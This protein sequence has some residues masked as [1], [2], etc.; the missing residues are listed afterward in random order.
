MAI[1]LSIL[2]PVS[3]L[4]I[5]VL[6]FITFK[7]VKHFKAKKNNL[8]NSMDIL[9]KSATID[10]S[11]DSEVTDMPGGA[12]NKE[13]G[14]SNTSSTGSNRGGGGY[15]TSSNS[16]GGIG[17]GVGGSGVSYNSNPAFSIP[18]T[19]PIPDH[20]RRAVS[21]I[22]RN[23]ADIKPSI[24]VHDI[25]LLA[26]RLKLINHD[27]VLKDSFAVLHLDI[28]NIEKLNSG[29]KIIK[30]LLDNSG[31]NKDPKTGKDIVENLEQYKD[32]FE[33]RILDYLES[34]MEIQR[35]PDYNCRIKVP[36][37]NYEMPDPSKLSLRYSEI[38]FF[39][40]SREA[41]IFYREKFD[42]HYK[43]IDDLTKNH[44]DLAEAI[45]KELNNRNTNKNFDDEIRNLNINIGETY[46]IVKSTIILIKEVEQYYIAVSNYLNSN[47]NNKD[48]RASKIYQE[49]QEGAK[50]ARETLR[51][52]SEHFE[53]A[54]KIV[55][56]LLINTETKSKTNSLFGTISE[57]FSNPSD[58]LQKRLGLLGDSFLES[59]SKVIQKGLDLLEKK[60]KILQMK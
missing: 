41:T 58:Y 51:N 4:A 52:Y 29:I 35:A 6:S 24:F 3:I 16:T 34:E 57:M 59:Y 31:K 7:V 44:K 25:K 37:G 5:G 43:K 20:V 54:D 26:E 33:K 23:S 19:P 38:K 9:N 36:T 47:K 53:S 11:K 49:H 2:I 56:K 17:S 39:S 60:V 18:T 12:R 14:T 15:S 13:Y 30:T 32:I 1:L 28:S 27:I 8:N 48:E 22:K 45:L 55:P 40:E 21:E 10:V 46:E 42:L 50:D